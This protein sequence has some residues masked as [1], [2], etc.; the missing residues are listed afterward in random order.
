M[1]VDTKQIDRLI[2]IDL[3]GAMISSKIAMNQMI[4]QEF[5]LPERTKC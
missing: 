1:E 3:K 5:E 4:K 2:D